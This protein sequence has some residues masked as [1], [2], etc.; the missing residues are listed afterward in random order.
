VTQGKET[1]AL[2]RRLREAMAGLQETKRS[3]DRILWMLIGGIVALAMA[4]SVMLARQAAAAGE[5]IL[6]FTLSSMPVDAPGAAVYVLDEADR[7][8]A[9]LG[10]DLPGTGARAAAEVRR[11]LG[12]GVRN[13]LARAAEGRALAAR[14]GV[15][16]LPAVVVDGRYAVYGIRDL[17]RALRLVEAWRQRE[18]PAGEAGS[19][20]AGRPAVR[21]GREPL[22]RPR[23]AHAGE[24]G[25]TGEPP[26]GTVSGND[27]RE[28]RGL[29]RHQPPART[30]PRGERKGNERKADVVERSGR[31]AEEE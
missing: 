4:G 10:R 22:T 2:K 21:G 11:R 27:T 30:L 18:G 20:A 31:G 13:R 28:R 1:G 6:V 8:A 15:E 5:K 23:R 25:G 14:L 3:L 29:P 24:G 26:P 9:A 12:A 16:R 17:D 19:R 7:L